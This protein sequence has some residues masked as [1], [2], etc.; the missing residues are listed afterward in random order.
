M[1]GVGVYVCSRV[2]GVDVVA[3]VWAVVGRRVWAW[4]KQRWA[5]L[6]S[7][8]WGVVVAE[9]GGWFSL[10]EWWGSAE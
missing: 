9:W 4:C 2:W 3:E 5:V 7:R 10:A 1:W 6:F 8:L